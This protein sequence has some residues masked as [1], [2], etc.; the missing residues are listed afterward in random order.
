MLVF[1]WTVITTQ[2]PT[3]RR[4]PTTQRRQYIL[5]HNNAQP[6]TNT[7]QTPPNTT[8]ISCTDA[9]PLH[10]KWH[11]ACTGNT[12][13]VV[14]CMLRTCSANREWTE[15]HA[16]WHSGK[17]ELC[18]QRKPTGRVIIVIVTDRE[19]KRKDKREQRKITRERETEEGE[20]RKRER[21][22]REIREPPSSSP[23]V[24]S[25]RPPCVGSKRFRVCRQNARMFN[26]EA[27]LRRFEPAHGVFFRVSRRATHHTPPNTQHTTIHHTTKTQNAHPTHTLNAH[28]QPHTTHAQHTT[29]H[30][31]HIHTPHT[32]HTPHTQSA[33][34]TL[35]AHITTT[36]HTLHTHCTHTHHTR[37]LGYAH[38]RQPTVILRRKSDCL[39][40]C[41]AV[42]HDLALDKNLQYL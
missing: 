20:E 41:T 16:H 35:H 32:Y 23:C 34:I 10:S 9:S 2:Q 3:H 31:P 30:T 39:D 40:L 15:A 27:F 33:H 14:S 42:N 13:T 36:T 21:D 24:G 5:S 19:E 28:A 8:P 4:Q 18:V 7:S 6:N 17:S 1:F 38:N 29:R 12:K 26:T 37:M 11:E 25:K 22:E